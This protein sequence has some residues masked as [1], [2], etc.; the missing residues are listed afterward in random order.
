MKTS[1]EQISAYL[2]RLQQLQRHA[3]GSL[4]SMEI[5]IATVTGGDVSLSV[6]I[7]IYE[8]NKEETATQVSDKYGTWDICEW[9]E[10]EVNDKA[11]SEIKKYMVKHKMI[12]A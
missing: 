1:K 11:I 12:E 2:E 3:L 5:R 9:R 7:H 6:F 8:W 10:K 4:H